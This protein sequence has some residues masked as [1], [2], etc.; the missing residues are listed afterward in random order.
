MKT[1]GT[2]PEKDNL[3]AGLVLEKPRFVPRMV[4][5]AELQTVLR[6]VIT[7]WRQRDRLSGLLKYE[8]RPLD[9]LIFYGP[10]GNGKTMACYWIAK[11]LGIPMYRVLC[12][13]LRGS[14]LGETARA[15]ADVMEYLDSSTE[16]ALCL[17]DE[18]ESIFIDR[19]NSYGQCDREIQAALTV[20][21]QHLDRW[22]APTLIVMATNL[23]DQLDEALLSR[24]EMRVNFV[25]PTQEQCRQLV[26]YW[27]EL[28]HDHGGA[29]WGPEL[30]AAFTSKGLPASF[31]ELRQWIGYAARNWAMQN[32]Q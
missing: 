26:A 29:K 31:R 10:P 5:T 11:E 19:K 13:Q 15:V 16:P 22:Q 24:V 9:R 20:F 3:P 8:I 12:N 4:M 7:Q 32:G 25:A 28:L 14:H 6:D 30:V 1:F 18:A 27:A 2:L 21:M 23:P 17:W